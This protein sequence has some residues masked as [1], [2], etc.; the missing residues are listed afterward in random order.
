MTNS[1]VLP[2]CMGDESLNSYTDE[3][4]DLAR[5]AH[6]AHLLGPWLIARVAES[7]GAE[8]TW[9]SKAMFIATLNDVQ[10]F[11]GMCA[12]TNPLWGENCHPQAVYT[13][14]FRPR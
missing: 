5:N 6:K 2:K 9:F 11:F 14:F 4:S 3:L 10:V 7:E 12:L 1:V 13:P 8:V